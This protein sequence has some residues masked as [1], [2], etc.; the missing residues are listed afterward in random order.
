[1]EGMSFKQEITST[2]QALRSD[3]ENR[4]FADKLRDAMTQYTSGGEQAEL[5]DV[6]TALEEA[7]AY[8]LGLFD[9]PLVVRLYEALAVCEQASREDAYRWMVCAAQLCE[10]H[11]LEQTEAERLYT[12]AKMHPEAAEALGR[13]EGEHKQWRKLADAAQEQA[14]LE[15]DPIKAAA[16]WREAA[17][18]VWGY[19]KKGRSG[20]F[21]QLFTK[22]L[23]TD[24]GKLSPILTYIHTLRDRDQFDKAQTALLK[25][26][27]HIVDKDSR[28]VIYL[29]AARLSLRLGDKVRA[30]ECYRFA[31]DIA[32]GQP[33]ALRYLSGLYTD[34]DNWDA[35]T[36]LYDRALSELKN[37]EQELGLVLQLA[38]IHW[39]MR[40][41]PDDALPYFS[42]LESLEPGHPALQEFSASPLPSEKPSGKVS[43]PPRNKRKVHHSV[44]QA[45][46][47]E[48]RSLVDRAVETWREVLTQ[49][50]ECEEAY[51]ELKRIYRNQQKWNAL[52]ELCN[53]QLTHVLKDVS[54]E[55]L[56]VLYELAELYRNEIQSDVRRAE[57]SEQI[58]KQRPDDQTARRELVDI[59]RSLRR[60]AQAYDHIVALAGLIDDAQ[61]R[62]GL[63]LEAA[64]MADEHLGKVELTVAALEGAVRDG[65][66]QPEVYS[67]LRGLYHRQRAWSALRDL[68]EHQSS[69]TD[70]PQV[71]AR[72]LKERATLVS[73]RFEKAEAYEAWKLALQYNPQDEDVLRQCEQF[74]EKLEDWQGLGGFLEAHFDVAQ[75]SDAKTNVA[76]R[77]GALFGDR[78]SRFDE[79]SHW[80][81][82]ALDID[83]SN[84]R[85]HHA[86]RDAYVRSQ[87]WDK[88]DTFFRNRG[89]FDALVEVLSSAADAQ[90]DTAARIALSLR[91][92]EVYRVDLGQPERAFRCYE[93]V[94]EA[95]PHHLGA[96]RALVPI[97]EKEE[98]W[99]RLEQVLQTLVSVLADN[100]AQERTEKLECL[101]RLFEISSQHLSQPTTTLEYA[102]Q[103]YLLEPTAN[104]QE[105]FEELAMRLGK[106]QDVV[107]VYMKQLESGS[108]AEKDALRRRVA[109]LAYESLGH[110]LLA[111]TQWRAVLEEHPTDREALDTLSA[112][113][114]KEQ[115]YT[116]LAELYGARLA[117]STSEGERLEL[118]ETLAVLQE[119][120]LKHPERAFD[121]LM[122]AWRIDSNF[123]GGEKLEAFAVA[124]GRFDELETIIEAQRR[125]GN[126]SPRHDEL[127]VRLA[128]RAL[129]E[130]SSGEDG[131]EAR[132]EKAWLF[133]EPVLTSGTINDE[134]VAVLE[135]LIGQPRLRAK[136]RPWLADIYQERR[137]F[138]LLVALWRDQLAE[139]DERV[140]RTTLRDQIVQ[141]LLQELNDPATALSLLVEAG[142]AGELEDHALALVDELATKTRAQ[143]M[144]VAFY[145]ELVAKAPDSTTKLELALRAVA[146]GESAKLPVESMISLYRAALACDPTQER[147][148]GI[149]RKHFVRNE[150][151]AELEGL[152]QEQLG[153]SEDSEVSIRWLLELGLLS[154]EILENDAQATEYYEKILALRSDHEEARRMLRQ[155]YA[156]HQAWP[157]YAH[158]LEQELSWAAGQDAVD[159]WFELAG[160]YEEKLSAPDKSFDYYRKIL[161]DQPSNVRAQEALERFAAQGISRDDIADILLP[162]YREQGA[163]RELVRLLRLL[164]SHASST[165]RRRELLREVFEVTDAKLENV[166]EALEAGLLLLQVEPEDFAL[167][168]RLEQL[169]LFQGQ[170]QGMIEVYETLQKDEKQDAMVR[171]ELARRLMRLTMPGVGVE[172]ANSSRLVVSTFLAYHPDAYPDE[173]LAAL[174]ELVRLY[175]EEKD[176]ERLS[177]TLE[178][179]ANADVS[180]DV[181]RE[182]LLRASDIY[183]AQQ[184]N[185]E[186]ALGLLKGWLNEDPNDVDAL[187]RLERIYVA[188]EQWDE[189]AVVMAQHEQNARTLEE[190][191]QL[192]LQLADI[193][194]DRLNQSKESF[195]LIRRVY[196]SFEY[197]AQVAAR[198][199]SLAEAH[200]DWDCFH[201]VALILAQKLPSIEARLEVELK[202]A[203]VLLNEQEQIDEAIGLYFELMKR[204]P[205]SSRPLEC[206]RDL[207]GHSKLDVKLAAARSLLPLYHPRKDAKILY[208]LYVVLF[209]SGD[210]DEQK[211]ALVQASKIASA[212][213]LD[214]EKAFQHQT[215]LLAL[216]KGDE[217]LGAHLSRWW[218]LVRRTGHYQDAVDHIVLLQAELWDPI[219][220][221]ENLDQA[222]EV[223]QSHLRS[224]D[225]AKELFRLALE[226][227]PDDLRALEGLESIYA[228]EQDHVALNEILQKKSDVAPSD[229]ARAWIDAQRAELLEKHLGQID[230]A[231]GLYERAFAANSDED[232]ARQLE[233]L[234]SSTGRWY[235]LIDLLTSE[236]ERR[237]AP[238]AQLYARI[239][240]VFLD[241]LKEPV[242]ALSNCEQALIVDDKNVEALA[243]LARLVNDPACSDHALQ[244]LD[245]AYVRNGMVRELLEII[246]VQLQKEDDR[247]RRRLLFVRAGELAEE[248]LQDLHQALDIYANWFQEDP[249]DEVAWESLDRVAKGTNEWAKLA[250]AYEVSLNRLA[251]EHEQESS[252][253][254]RLAYEAGR[255]FD[256]KLSDRHKAE[257]YYEQA[258]RGMNSRALTEALSAIYEQTANYQ[259][260]AVLLEDQAQQK[261]SP[262]EQRILLYRRAQLLHEHVGDL[263]QA[264]GAYQ[265]VLQVDPSF[266]PAIEALELCYS[267]TEQWEPLVELLRERV[268]IEQEPNIQIELKNR[269]ARILASK[270]ARPGDALDEIEDVTH[271][272]AGYAPGTD[273]LESLLESGQF[274]ERIVGLLEVAYKA[275]RQWQPLVAV[276]KRALPLADGAF[277]QDLRVRIAE[278]YQ[279]Y[280]GHHPDTLKAWADVV[281][282]APSNVDYQEAFEAVAVRLGAWTEL[283]GCYRAA[284]E[285]TDDVEAKVL[286]LRKVADTLYQIERPRNEVIDAY[287]QVL[288]VAPEDGSVLE[289]LAQLLLEQNDWPGFIDIRRRQLTLSSDSGER[290]RIYFDIAST[291][292][293]SL[294][295]IDEAIEAY[296]QTIKEDASHVEALRALAVLYHEKGQ[297]E[298]TIRVYTRLYE[299]EDDPAVRGDVALR[300]AAVAESLSRHDEVIEA[301]LCAQRELGDVLPI[302]ETL[303][304]SYARTQRWYEQIDTLQMMIEKFHA[305]GNRVPWML[306]MAQA[307]EN[308]KATEQAAATCLVLV[309]EQ[310]AEG[311]ALDRLVR[312]F[313]QVPAMHAEIYE[314]VASVLSEAGRWA[315]LRPL[316]E[317]KID[318]TDD[319]AQKHQDMIQLALIL[320]RRL[321]ATTDAWRIWL[322]LLEDENYRESALENLERL[323]NSDEQ[324]SE[325]AQNIEKGSQHGSDDERVRWA[326]KA[327]ALWEQK[328]RD[329]DKA[330]HVLEGLLGAGVIDAQLFDELERIYA[331]QNNTVALE[332]L[333]RRRLEYVTDADAQQALNRRLAQS[334][335]N[336][337]DDSEA[338]VQ[339]WKSLLSDNDDA[340]ALSAL[341][342]L[343][344]KKG[345]FEELVELWWQSRERAPRWQASER[346]IALYEQ[347]EQSERSFELA[348]EEWE[349]APGNI[350]AKQWVDKLVEKSGR[351]EE[352]LTLSERLLGQLEAGPAVQLNLRLAEVAEIKLAQSERAEMFLWNAFELDS[353]IE[354]I[355]RLRDYFLR[356]N[357]QEEWVLCVH[358]IIASMPNQAEKLTLLKEAASFLKDKPEL[359][360]DYT[361]VLETIQ[362]LVPV[363][364]ETVAEL[365]REYVR[366]GHHAKASQVLNAFVKAQPNLRGKDRSVIFQLL[367]EATAG[368]GEHEEALVYYEQAT[369]ADINNRKTLLDYSR[370]CYE[371]GRYDKA[372]N[373]FRALL[374]QKNASDVGIERADLYYYLSDIAAKEGDKTKAKSLAERALAE[375]QGHEGARRVLGDIASV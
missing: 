63:W 285:H 292:E 334:M 126:L 224:I 114:E 159:I 180:P 187:E 44:S 16:L 194:A 107:D 252:L 201:D 370:L 171:L 71:R 146:L 363:E 176:Y 248:H 247:A 198:L 356:N 144:V 103:A 156:K 225:R 12:Q 76:L 309:R 217:D 281:Q 369:K 283:V 127:S 89:D 202:R 125:A 258:Y 223:A 136:V 343:L 179:K 256:E 310:G 98:R 17:R 182:C 104:Y 166:I 86:L 67:W 27:Q 206:L 181:R 347:L 209:E 318:A 184:D 41:A 58:L 372:Q 132:A 294:R 312:L 260:L 5:S 78:L 300:W 53:A 220:R 124:Q 39:K 65:A 45:R 332:N 87:Q 91:A 123:A 178:D 26:V 109:R 79:S 138:D 296:E 341:D 174:D 62:R 246:R 38:M 6:K 101:D 1:M 222:A 151:W 267:A 230:E 250:E 82:K 213:L 130:A 351:W 264:V 208:E 319:V 51:V 175:G 342:M 371:L 282:A 190:Q 297:P 93:R 57:V 13:I 169:A 14:A 68:L 85:A 59:Y 147:I 106:T 54:A 24:P 150:S 244:I 105:R 185:S 243:L 80:Y 70:D 95:E 102:K 92:A 361:K 227:S 112:L 29:Q 52:S 273:I 266:V 141:V 268:A 168:D 121:Y 293:R 249:H 233:R 116:E 375:N 200:K 277:G 60:F 142:R 10:R 139:T 46:E 330:T 289:L 177:K 291:Y 192:L 99:G 350:D 96:L 154:H 36:Q 212:T 367:G 42:R 306:A 186:H 211:N 84:T 327:A 287:R 215:R 278:T 232:V 242:T 280:A 315:E 275:T 284:A 349:N 231:I 236:I 199:L 111:K 257:R 110:A 160:L 307:Y 221:A 304:R 368:A 216:A 237:M 303:S 325:L 163:Y 49:D 305:S 262:V 162:L 140:E 131:N 329:L 74:A 128:K 360:T 270:L 272:F 161:E 18:L 48:Q 143:A 337:G 153:A 228:S 11:L 195:Q 19:R 118:L 158:L 28:K 117:S 301:T 75:A 299:V 331:S 35:L 47:L 241:H 219:L 352:W 50:P 61:A 335:L 254:A 119:Q 366:Q 3:P 204:Y 322:V 170:T 259:K 348:A 234:Y 261:S 316:L 15:Q 135:Q 88:I 290:A 66:T 355:K 263:S 133:I 100:V 295:Q 37:T 64:S 251:D 188:R 338:L 207:V 240:L 271:R 69:N 164:L 40:R 205:S 134:T 73:E 43:S 56:A 30:E 308:A 353:G 22:S 172:Q 81:E 173:R 298:D 165:E 189:L 31:H 374:L 288:T 72:V 90:Q 354:V 21:E 155:L 196:D 238:A 2:L 265:Q 55:R 97:Y 157:K 324:F 359:S 113:L 328:I 210:V 357:R 333:W 320:E 276:Y 255:L 191:K 323:A 235:P 7:V 34:T 8:H 83:A 183:V 340:E 344:T 313:A 364:L 245:T 122:Q 148:Y 94:L 33:E 4:A 317:Q 226:A 346:L 302:L 314:V 203:H 336:R 362:S 145:G 193:H 253:A 120:H 286:L 373:G 77:L 149:L 345:R 115:S 218:D 9:W 365:A 239:A 321:K 137:R 326:L 214:D 152:F 23:E 269:I 129:A 32:P 339:V 167:C 229:D 108:A 197:D 311:E 20:E 25:V 358:R 279:L 274:V